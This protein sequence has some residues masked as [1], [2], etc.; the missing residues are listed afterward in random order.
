VAPAAIARR[1]AIAQGAPVAAGVLAAGSIG[2]LI[3][4][5]WQVPAVVVPIHVVAGGLCAAGFGPAAAARPRLGRPGAT[6]A[7]AGLAAIAAASLWLAGS[8][9][10]GA[11]EL[12]RSDDALARGDAGEA[13]ELARSAARIQPWAAEPYVRLAEIEQGVGNIEA[14][15]A[16]TVAA[17]DRAPDDFRTWILAS[18]L[19]IQA[20]HSKAGAAYAQRAVSL[21]P[22]LLGRIT[23]FVP[24][25]R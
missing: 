12:Q 20:G 5:T 1:K 9:G 18:Q 7:A 6:L 11:N 25:T 23:E 21:A 22:T 16:A 3:D 4:W 8:L 13:A 2:L 24:E 15:R 17:I 19:S 14:A 10:V